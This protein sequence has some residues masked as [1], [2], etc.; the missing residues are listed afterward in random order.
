MLGLTNRKL[1]SGLLGLA[2]L[3]GNALEAT[4]V[5]ARV[6]PTAHFKHLSVPILGLAIGHAQ[7]PVGVVSHVIIHFKDRSDQ[8][9]LRIRFDTKP[10]KFSPL[11]QHAVKWAIERVAAAAH[12]ET[13]SW[14]VSLTF[15]NPGQ[16]MYGES[17][18]AMVGLSV[19][20][21]AKGDELIDGRSITG[22]ITEDGRIGKVGGI[23]QKVYAAYDEHLERI[24]IP[25]EHDVRDDDW[26][27]PFLMHVSHVD[28]VDNAYLALTGHRLT[29][30]LE[31]S[32]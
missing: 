32:F 16:T 20:A 28:T 12:L 6:T 18:S 5:A 23:P 22:T 25:E 21:L 31:S 26:Q 7:R 8:E 24:L 4:P 3:L 17:L 29:S 15:P 11:A 1:L 13:L 30:S 10:G 2:F 9:G 14:T 19:A 27:I